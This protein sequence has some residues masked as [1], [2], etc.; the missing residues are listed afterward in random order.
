MPIFYSSK[1]HPQE[2]GG[3]YVAPCYLVTHAKLQIPLKSRVLRVFVRVYF[4]RPITLAEI[5]GFS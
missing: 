4:A 1:Q 2:K 3:F 5:R